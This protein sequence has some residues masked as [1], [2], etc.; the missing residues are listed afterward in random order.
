MTEQ[1]PEEFRE[2]VSDVLAMAEAYLLVQQEDAVQA[3]TGRSN[4]RFLME[5]ADLEGCLR[6]AVPLLVCG[7]EATSAVQAELNGTS[8][9]EELANVLAMFREQLSRSRFT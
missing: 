6:V 2:C 5:H 3:S 4:F 8:T 9:D 7:W 1:F